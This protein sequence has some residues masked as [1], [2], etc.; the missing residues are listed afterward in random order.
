MTVNLPKAGIPSQLSFLLNKWDRGHFRD[1]LEKQKSKIREISKKKRNTNAQRIFDYSSDKSQNA[2]GVTN[3]RIESFQQRKTVRN[4]SAKKPILDNSKI[5]NGLSTVSLLNI[6]R[7]KGR[8]EIMS[9]TVKKDNTIHNESKNSN[10]L[11][12]CLVEQKKNSTLLN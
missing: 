5:S 12:S 6:N 4:S 8:N 3:Q 11:I 2:N 1:M 10:S 7:P 9:Q